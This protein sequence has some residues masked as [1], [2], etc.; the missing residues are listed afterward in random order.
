MGIYKNLIFATILF[1]LSD[2]AQS[3]PVSWAGG[4][5]IMYRTNSMMSSYTFHYSPTYKYSIGAE[6]VNDRY[7]NNH[8]INL[9]STYLL[10]RH[11]TK[12]SQRNIYLTG[13]ISTKTNQ[14]FSYGIHGDW[15]TRR[16][17]SSFSLINKHTKEKDYTENEFQLGVAPYLGKYDDIHTW[18]MLKA[19]KNTINNNWEIYP[20][21]KLFQGDFLIEVGSKNSH[22]D[23]HFIIRY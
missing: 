6:Y 10:D 18:V 22:W 19:K 5:T 17:F 11:N 7:F 2:L 13:G 14:D 3:R 8:F 23:V 9:R 21:I 12:I 1:M 16:L 15:E 4:S 20:F